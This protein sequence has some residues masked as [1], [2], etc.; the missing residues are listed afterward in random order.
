MVKKSEKPLRKR[1]LA[2]ATVAGLALYVAQAMAANDVRLSAGVVFA[3]PMEA[4]DTFLRQPGTGYIRAAFRFG[5]E[6]ADD[7]ILFV[8]QEMLEGITQP[9]YFK[10]ADWMSFVG[11]Q[12]TG[13]RWF[14]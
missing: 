1:F 7:V 12:R 8:D 9:V 11:V 10:G 3:P 2:W 13:G 5:P 14:S 4:H 6:L